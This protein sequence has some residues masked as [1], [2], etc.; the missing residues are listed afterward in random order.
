MALVNEY[1]PTEASV[2]CTASRADLAPGDAVVAIG[3]PIAGARVHILDGALDPAPLGMDGEIWVAGV[4]LARGYLERP[5]LTAER[6]VPDPHGEAGDRLYRTGDLGR[7]R[8]DGTIEYRGRSDDQL[9]IRGFRIEPGEIEAALR[10][11]SG[12]KAAAVV[13]RDTPTGKELVGFV[14]GDGD[15]SDGTLADRVRATLAETLPDFMLPARLRRIEALP[16][17]ANGKLDREAL[18]A[19]DTRSRDYVAPRTELERALADSWAEAL[20]VERVGMHDNFFELG[21][22]SLLAA[23]LRTRIQSRLGIVLPLRLF[24]EG[25]TLEQFAAKVVAHRDRTDGDARLDAFESLLVSA[26]A[27]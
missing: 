27:S 2:W 19:L 11:C 16:T 18:L 5:G 21:G 25:D 9:K 7:Y 12:V 17:N 14:V 4:G 8:P 1:G 10:R 15:A 22:H 20:S 23:K 24:F 26:E 13:A 3:R 6:F